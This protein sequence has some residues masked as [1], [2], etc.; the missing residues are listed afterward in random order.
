MKKLIAII[1]ITTILVVVM[2]Q[3]NTYEME[4]TFTRYNEITDTTGN[5]WEYH[6]NDFRVGDTVTIVFND[7]G[8]TNRTDDIIKE[9]KQ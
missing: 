4:G 5:V 2:S 6:T 9:V 7:R 8:T 1:T 3:L